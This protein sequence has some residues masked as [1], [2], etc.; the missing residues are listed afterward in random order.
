MPAPWFADLTLSGW[1]TLLVPSI[2]L[3][4][5]ALALI[6]GRRALSSRCQAPPPAPAA[7]P[8]AP[9]L[10]PFEHGSVSEKRQAVRRSG[11]PVEVQVVDPGTKAP[12]TNGWVLDRSTGGLSLQ[13][14]DSLAPNT[15]VS[16]RPTKAP[17][18]MP[19][20]EVEVRSCRPQNGGWEIGCKYLRTPPWSVQL[21][22]G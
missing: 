3:T 2:G 14:F 21:L 7:A 5:A 15:V 4:F 12:L 18:L 11:N 17:D 16:V 9:D 6:V 8:P 19:W 10:D 1:Q 20:V 22:F 13:L